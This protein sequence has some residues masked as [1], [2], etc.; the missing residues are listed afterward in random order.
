MN[1]SIY[2]PSSRCELLGQVFGRKQ[3]RLE[4]GVKRRTLLSIMDNMD[5]PLLRKNTC[6]FAVVLTR[7]SK[8]FLLTVNNR[9]EY[10][11]QFPKSDLIVIHIALS[12]SEK[13]TEANV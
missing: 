8:Y 4:Q 1:Q 10:H 7:E 5:H 6:N 11:D 13:V 12:I 3:G 2:L 9:A